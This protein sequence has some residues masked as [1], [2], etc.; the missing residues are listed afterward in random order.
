MGYVSVEDRNSFHVVATVDVWL[1]AIIAVPMIVASL[2]IFLGYEI[3]GR[4]R[5]TSMDGLAAH[6]PATIL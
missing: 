3:S 1:W 6:V 5:I 2:L 4:R